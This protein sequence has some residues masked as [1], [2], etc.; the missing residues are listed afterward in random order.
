MLP[1]T[2]EESS[3]RGLGGEGLPVNLFGQVRPIDMRPTAEQSAKIAELNAAAAA[4]RAAHYDEV[5][6]ASWGD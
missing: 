1:Q 3:V 5:L 6:E 4:S 2:F